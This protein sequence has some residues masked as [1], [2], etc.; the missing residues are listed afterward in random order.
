M[1]IIIIPNKE[2]AAAWLLHSALWGCCG[3]AVVSSKVRFVNSVSGG[4]LC[5]KF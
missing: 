5:N 1:H 2:N 4:D 3:K